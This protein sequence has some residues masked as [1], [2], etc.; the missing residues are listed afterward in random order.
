MTTEI[1][2]AQDLARIE[3]RA[4]ELLQLPIY[5][6]ASNIYSQSFR[7]EF[8]DLAGFA[9]RVIPFTAIPEISYAYAAGYEGAGEYDDAGFTRPSLKELEEEDEQ[10]FLSGI[11]YLW[12][13]LTSEAY[14]AL[15]AL[16]AQQFNYEILHRL[17]LAYGITDSDF[18]T[19][20][21]LAFYAAEK[22]CTR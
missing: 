14:A 22:E 19:D 20:A 10:D 9:R 3:A 15:E 1:F 6:H 5:C 2:K 7:E 16:S 8:E 12:D 11:E 17:M 18:M 21:A 13:Y 4:L